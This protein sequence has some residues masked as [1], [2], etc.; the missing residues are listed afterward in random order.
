MPTR[1]N[2]LQ[3]Q[4]LT[5]GQEGQ[6]TALLDYGL[7]I[8]HKSAAEVS[9]IL[10][11]DEY[12]RQLNREYRG[13]DQPTDV[14]SFAMAEG[15]TA[16]GVADLP[17]LLGDIYISK[18]RAAVQADAYGHSFQRELCYLAVHGLLHL[19]GFDH[20]TPEA[21]AV[22]REREEQIMREFGLERI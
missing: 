8:F 3:A 12:L 22:M 6:I 21:T 20:Q 10:A 16:P 7:G 14:L 1:L 13:I 5:A 4:S 2:N 11:D 17:E 18:T 19:L 15:L 9:L